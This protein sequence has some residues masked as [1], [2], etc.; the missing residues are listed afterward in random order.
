MKKIKLKVSYSTIVTLS[1]EIGFDGLMAINGKLVELL[2]ITES[3]NDTNNVLADLLSKLISID[4]TQLNTR[5]VI[6][7]NWTIDEIRKI[8]NT[9]NE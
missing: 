8:Q 3:E 7:I 9:L 1:K 4:K 6:G 5:Q 2:E